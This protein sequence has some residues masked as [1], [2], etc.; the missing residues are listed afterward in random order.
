[1]TFQIIFTLLTAAVMFYFLIVTRKSAIRRLF[2][3][4]FFGAGIVSIVDPGLTT[5]IAN[6][7]GIGRGADLVFYLSTLFLVFLC[8][9]FHLRFMALQDQLTRVVREIALRNPVHEEDAASRR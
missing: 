2:V 5:E 9:N 6:M 7:V 4:F 3:L 1:M 8:F